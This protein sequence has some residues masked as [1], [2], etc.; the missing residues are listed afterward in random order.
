MSPT[1]AARIRHPIPVSGRRSFDQHGRRRCPIPRF[2]FGCV[3][4]EAGP[5]PAAAGSSWPDIR[6]YPQVALARSSTV[7]PQFC[8]VVPKN[9]GALTSR[10]NSIASDSRAAFVNAAA[11]PMVQAVRRYPRRQSCRQGQCDYQA[12]GGEHEECNHEHRYKPDPQLD[13]VHRHDGQP[14]VEHAQLELGG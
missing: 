14:W 8:P 13:L 10:N 9:S 5:P 1:R 11:I 6:G 4:P 3:V 2:V 12:G 7:F